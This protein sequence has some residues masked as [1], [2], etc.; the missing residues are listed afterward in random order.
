[1]LELTLVRHAKSSWADAGQRDFDRP[2]NPRG[3]RDAP[4]MAQWTARHL[5]PPDLIVSSPAQRALSTAR[6]FAA[7]LGIVDSRLRLEPG[8][9]EAS[10][11]TLMGILCMLDAAHRRVM[12]FGHNPGISELAQRLGDGTCD[13]LP[14]CALASFSL[15]VTRWIDLADGSGKLQHLMTPKQL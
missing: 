10:A 15:C 1:M 12:L 6:V 4:R 8:I 11:D 9:Y 2:L 13:E 3:E 14:T 7:V 5:S